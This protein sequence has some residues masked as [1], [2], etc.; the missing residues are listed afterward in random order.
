MNGALVVVRPTPAS[1]CSGM[2]VM[3]LSS[4]LRVPPSRDTGALS[5]NL[6][7]MR[8]SRFERRNL[9]FL[10]GNCG[11]LVIEEFKHERHGSGPN[12]LALERLRLTAGCRSADRGTRCGWGKLVH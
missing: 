1:C 12:R 7:R 8:R 3:V 5:L 2:V 10:V 4:F 6:N 11:A 9:D